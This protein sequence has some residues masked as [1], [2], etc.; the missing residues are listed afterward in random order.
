MGNL[1][2]MK[3]AITGLP[4][5]VQAQISKDAADALRN[6]AKTAAARKAFATVALDIGLLY[7]ATAIL[8]SAVAIMSGDST[9]D[10]EAQGYARRL[11]N[12]LTRIKE[13]PTDLLNPFWTIKSLLPQGE[14]E[15][16]K[17]NRVLVGY[18]AD[19]TGIYMNP[20]PGKIGGEFE[21]WL[22]GPLD[23]MRRKAGTIARP[24]EQTISND[25][26]FG[27]KIYN[28]YSMSP[29]VWMHNA[30]KIAQLF[31]ADQ[32]PMVALSAARDYLAGRGSKSV[33]I[34]QMLGPLLGATFSKGA[35]GGPA[36]GEMY[37]ARDEYRIKLGDSLPSIRRQIADGDLA[38]ARQ[39]MIEIGIPKALQDFY[40]K[41]T[42]DPRTRLSTRQLK[43]FWQYAN[44]DQRQ[45]MERF[46][47]RLQ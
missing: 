9:L 10:K 42:L 5:D 39:K 17:D 37:R 28:P 7:A 41:T 23:M 32:V 36:V 18:A 20:P 4:K 43:D 38:G 47:Q 31:F 11:N 12:L 29:S 33:E 8:S 40:V 1:G 19:G 35:P 15:P 3:D 13:S 30:G 6:S 16:G 45:D 44:P 22:T 14:N 46:L 2:A 25:D 26:G 21:G 34:A 24:I 27:N